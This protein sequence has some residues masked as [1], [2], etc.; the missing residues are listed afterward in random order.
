M[1]LSQAQ[2]DD[3]PRCY[4]AFT[5]RMPFDDE[6]SPFTT[7]TVPMTRQEAETAFCRWMVDEALASD[8]PE[9]IFSWLGLT[10]AADPRQD[11]MEVVITTNAFRST[12]PITLA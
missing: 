8:T 10:P 11:L 9:E 1:S 2:P 6:D 4:W 3:N 7:E 5:G 12:E